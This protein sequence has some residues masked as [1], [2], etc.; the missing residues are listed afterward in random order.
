MA[1]GVSKPSAH[2]AN[3]LRATRAHHPNFTLLLGAGASAESSVPTGNELVK[4]WRE[5]FAKLYCS[6][7]NPDAEL[8][9]QTWYGQ[10]DEYARLFETL[11]DQPSQR[12]EFIEQCLEKAS[13]SWGYIYL[14][15]LIQE[16]VFN[17]IFTTNFD[18]L[19]NEACYQFSTDVRPLVCAHDSSIRSVRVTSKR[20]KIVKLHG[21][22]LFDSIK[23]TTRELES[24]ETNIRDKFR[25]FAG[26]Y[27][28]IVVGYAGR[29]RSVM[30]TL[31]SL[32]RSEDNFPHGIYWCVRDQ[33][34]ISP[35]VDA[36][37][38]F[39]KFNLVQIPGFDAFM[40]ELHDAVEIGRHPV[41]E[42]PFNVIAGRFNALMRNLRV[43]SDGGTLHPALE[44]DAALLGDQLMRGI[45]QQQKLDLPFRLLAWNSRKNKDLAKAHQ[46]IL[47]HIR[48]LKRPDS[49]PFR[50]AIEVLLEQWDSAVFAAMTSELVRLVEMRRETISWTFDLA[51][52][53]M[54]GRRYSEA[55]DILQAFE[56]MVA[57]SP[58]WVQDYH[59]INVKQ[60]FRHEGIALGDVEETRARDM[61][62][63]PF[64]PLTRLGACCLLGDT[65]AALEII[66]KHITPD[67]LID[68]SPWEVIRTWPIV[69][70]IPT[71]TELTVPTAISGNIP[72][73]TSNVTILEPKS[74][75]S[76]GEPARG[77]TTRARQ[78]KKS[79]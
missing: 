8:T 50:F 4:Q 35:E 73:S 74:T 55:R 2:V 47:Q 42:N 16:R 76:T 71:L 64:P 58:P 7:E 5:T 75:K 17:A 15:H 70:L 49:E 39:S 72:H 38:R 23:N 22:F 65:N 25:Q 59:W 79:T 66:K 1:T 9:G 78:R 56:S 28:M 46:H 24:L 19:L 6:K 3:I 40:C 60:T 26:E 36:L 45:N 30:D 12:R 43:P 77:V 68:G 14:V 31:D 48:S 37:Q 11:Y 62:L 34:S 53:L 41:I 44:R 13:P 18:D 51:I 61:Q 32:L 33:K 63:Q 52:L 54:S 69:R 21:D 20:P 67:G 27:G 29:D 10:P 57:T